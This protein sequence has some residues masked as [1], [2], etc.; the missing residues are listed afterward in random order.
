M[1]RTGLTGI[2]IVLSLVSAPAV[3]SAQIQTGSV[4]V[5]A[6]DAQG[7]VV[8]GATITLTS[9]V[10][11]SA[12]TGVTDETGAYRFPSLSVGT[13]TVKVALTGFQTINREN[14]VVRQG[15]TV[16]V[17]IFYY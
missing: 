3:A 8:P 10:L 15:Q 6:V 14:V 16:T 4:F 11:P 13:Y 7:A 9:P 12:L 2:L 17:D 5:K 1:L